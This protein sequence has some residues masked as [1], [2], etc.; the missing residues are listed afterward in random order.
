MGKF[1]IKCGMVLQDEARYCN[2]CGTDQLPAVPLKEE[3]PVQAQPLRKADLIQTQPPKSILGRVA[4][5]TAA[6]VVVICTA[7]YFLFFTG[8]ETTKQA[9]ATPASETAGGA[10]AVIADATDQPSVPPTTQPVPTVS[11]QTITVDMAYDSGEGTYTGEIKNGVPHGQGSFEMVK[12]DND[13]A[14]TYEGQWENGK[15][16]GKGTLVSG[17][18]VYTGT[19][20]DGL[21][22]GSFKIMDGSVL[23]YEGMCRNNKLQ[24]KG[25]LYTRSGSLLF[26]G[27]FKN[28]M[29]VE[30]AAEREKRGEAFQRQCENMNAQLYASCL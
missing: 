24:G 10:A 26:E 1:C 23:R 17:D 6:A 2:I 8:N 9:A 7:S 14:W 29:L 28:D 15:I 4:I 30:S 16:T 25:K 18:L 21:L 27:T 20:R 19:F 3:T 22:N 11:K 12:S 13:R 5:I